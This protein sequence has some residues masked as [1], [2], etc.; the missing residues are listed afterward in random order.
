MVDLSLRINML[1]GAHHHILGRGHVDQGRFLRVG[2]G[3]P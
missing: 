2:M 3:N 1:A